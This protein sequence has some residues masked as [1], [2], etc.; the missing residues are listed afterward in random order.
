[1]GSISGGGFNP[2]VALGLSMSGH[3]AWSSLW[4]YIIAPVLGAVVGAVLFRVLNA[5]DAKKVGAE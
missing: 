1:M 5:D 2:A 3:V 4:L